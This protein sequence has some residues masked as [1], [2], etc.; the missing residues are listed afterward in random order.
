MLSSGKCVS[1]E[2]LG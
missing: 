1:Q 2:I